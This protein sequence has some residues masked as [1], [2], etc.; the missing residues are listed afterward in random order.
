MNLP[1]LAISVRQPWAWAIIFAGK[2]IENRA[3]HF[4]NPAR[5]HRGR[6]A[7]HA[8]LGMTKAE[9]EKAAEFMASIGIKCPAPADLVR[10]AVIGCITIADGVNKNNPAAQSPWFFGPFGL[11]LREP[12]PL[13]VPVP[14]AGALGF[15]AWQ[16]AEGG[17][18]AEPSKWM[19]ARKVEQGAL[20]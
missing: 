2:D 7:L 6:V 10:G 3:W 15:F 1:K 14:A 18:V 12:E 9:Y 4:G 20:L 11:V 19:G 13:L 17:K 5:R 8:S 16:P